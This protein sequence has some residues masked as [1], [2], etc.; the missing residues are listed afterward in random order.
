[1]AVAIDRF[2][3]FT[4]Q[5]LNN[6]GLSTAAAGDLT[7]F[8]ARGGVSRGDAGDAIAF[9]NSASAGNATLTYLLNVKDANRF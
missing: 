3:S 6:L 1:M 8:T 9:F 4:G 7:T 2:R 5:L